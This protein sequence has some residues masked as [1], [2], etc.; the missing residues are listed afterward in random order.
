MGSGVLGRRKLRAT[1]GWLHVKE[2]FYLKRARN[3][4]RNWG[5]GER[6][7]E[8]RRCWIARWIYTASGCFLRPFYTSDRS[9]SAAGDSQIRNERIVNPAEGGHLV[10]SLAVFVS[11]NKG[12]FFL[13]GR[14]LLGEW[15]GWAPF[16]IWRGLSCQWLH[17]G[18]ICIGVVVV[19]VGGGVERAVTVAL[20]TGPI[21]STVQ[22]TVTASASF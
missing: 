16:R 19:V 3:K 10:N 13:A 12:V 2:S 18:G 8:T 11:E 5:K 17:G 22:V 14:P 15:R 4:T 20:T 6:K 9:C 1:R 7:L 21:R